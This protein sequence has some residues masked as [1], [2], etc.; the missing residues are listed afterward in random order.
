MRWIEV[1]NQTKKKVPKWIR[2]A[3]LADDGT[4]YIPAA[5]SGNEQAALL[6]ASW[7][8]ISMVSY[9][10]HIFLP[11]SWLAKEYPMTQELCIKIERRLKEVAFG[12]N[13]SEP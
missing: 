9:L 11:T 4:V 10:N 5:V 6:S 1:E 7:D 12:Q 2:S 8:G 13:S 3:G